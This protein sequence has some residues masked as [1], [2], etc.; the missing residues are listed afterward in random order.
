[1]KTNFV[2]KVLSL[3]VV[4]F[5][6]IT[7]LFGNV[8]VTYAAAGSYTKIKLPYKAEAAV[9]VTGDWLTHNQ[10]RK[11]TGSHAVDIGMYLADV[12]A[13][14]SGTVDRYV[15]DNTGGGNVLIIDN[16]D[17][18]CSIYAHLNKSY[19]STKYG[20]PIYQGQ[21]IAQSGHSSKIVNGKAVYVGYH[22]HIAITKKTSSKCNVDHTQELA[23]FFDEKPGG[24]LRK[25]EKIISRNAVSANNKT[26]DV[27]GDGKADIVGF[28]DD[29]VIVALSTGSSFQSGQVWANEFTYNNG[30]WRVE[31]NPRIVADVNGD[32]KA[33]IVGF[34]NDSVIVALS[35]DSNFQPGQVWTHEFT[36]S[37]GGW[38]VEKNPRIAADVNGD[39]K[40]DIVGFGD[41]GLIVALSTGSGFQPGQV[42]THEFTYNYGGWRVEKHIRISQTK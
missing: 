12:Y 22:L 39:G 29:S 35:T 30:S 4:F 41:D 14:H 37:Y 7:L 13:M 32:G 9:L 31:K 20:T 15:W 3:I 16:Q 11:T 24:E 2:F 40:A 19:V 23:M 18:Y 21:V 5:T 25:G 28:G 34:G 10:E 26:V 33:D 42:W 17:G 6:G 1:M 38:S 8:Q 27:N 36:Y